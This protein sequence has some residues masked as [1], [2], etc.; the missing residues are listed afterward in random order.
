[1]VGAT[2]TLSNGV[3]YNRIVFHFQK[4]QVNS[5]LHTFLNPIYG[6]TMPSDKYNSL[7]TSNINTKVTLKADV[8]DLIDTWILNHVQSKSIHNTVLPGTNNLKNWLKRI[9]WYLWFYTDW[10]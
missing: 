1:M 10:E 4:N 5:W 7:F 6:Q 9:S 3:A 8:L 2:A